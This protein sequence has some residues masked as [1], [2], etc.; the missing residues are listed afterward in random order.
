MTTP[1]RGEQIEAK[2][3]GC[4]PHELGGANLA[5]ARA[6]DAAIAEAVKAERE[7]IIE[8][9]NAQAAQAIVDRSHHALSCVQTIRSV[10]QQRDEADAAAIRA[11]G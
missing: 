9:C 5:D 8:A 3:L 11:R 1:T 10:I 2:R 6:I 7:A 4:E